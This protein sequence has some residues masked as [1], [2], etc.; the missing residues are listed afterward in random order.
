MQKLLLVED[1]QAVRTTMVT[2]LELEGYDVEAVSSTGEAMA[3][4]SENAY[5]IVISDIYIDERTVD[6]HVG[7]LRKAIN[8]GDRPDI[9]RTV[10][11][12]GYALDSG[13]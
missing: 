10:R 6:V 5:P 1:D 8:R 12:A 3:R 7:R 4:L 2:C 13:A 9:I 11:S